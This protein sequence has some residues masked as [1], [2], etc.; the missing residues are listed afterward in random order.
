MP[1]T[2]ACDV[3]DG[4][5]FT[6]TLTSSAGASGGGPFGPA[7]QGRAPLPTMIESN[8]CDGV[9]ITAQRGCGME[10]QP[11]PLGTAVRRVAACAAVTAILLSRRR[12]HLPR[13]RVGMRLR[14]ADGTSSRVYRE[15]VIDR[16][17]PED[18]CVLIVAFRLRM[19]RGWGHQLFRWESVCNTPLFVGFPGF[20]SKLWMAHDD[21]GVYRGLYEWDGPDQAEAYARALWW[22]L[23]LVSVSDSIRYWVLPGIRRDVLFAG[24]RVSEGVTPIGLAEWWRPVEVA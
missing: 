15:T 7:R 1:G 13:G 19:I 18:P 3:A 10:Q 16:D 20:V 11:L 6:R 4:P 22:V 9:K 17:P 21:A 12:V 24:P 2:T 8:E 14:F 23:A 5:A